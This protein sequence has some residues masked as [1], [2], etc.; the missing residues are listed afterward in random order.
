MS[1]LDMRLAL[2]PLLCL[3]LVYSPSRM[4]ETPRILL[5]T[6][7]LYTASSFRYK[8]HATTA[9]VYLASMMWKGCRILL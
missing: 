8:V 4:S 9:L 3:F 1:R 2:S 5:W 7:A 6:S